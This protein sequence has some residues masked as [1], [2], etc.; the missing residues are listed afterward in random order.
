MSRDL[1][2]NRA[3][4]VWRVDLIGNQA[5]LEAEE[6]R[7]PRL[8]ADERARL[9]GTH[10]SPQRLAHIALR[11]CLEATTGAVY[12]GLP[13]QRGPTGKPA[14]GGNAPH[15]SLA[16]T[17]E[18]ALIAVSAGGPVGVDIEHERVVTLSDERRQAIEAAAQTLSSRPLPGSQPA[19]NARFLQAWTRLEA[20]AKCTGEGIGAVLSATELRRE[21][22]EAPSGIRVSDLTMDVG[23]YAALAGPARFASHVVHVFPAGL[24]DPAGSRRDAATG[25]P[26]CD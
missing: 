8:P 13:F 4:D 25:K 2:D 9:A 17:R 24:T 12:R 5:F 21:R 16:H 6:E 7:T 11:M 18:V 26:S 10:K 19:T 20:L 15:F 1:T 23:S 3:I 14:L 22:F